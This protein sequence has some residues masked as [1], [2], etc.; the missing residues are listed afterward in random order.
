MIKKLK[1]LDIAKLYTLISKDFKVLSPQEISGVLT[2]T[3]NACF[4][5]NTLS[6]FQTVLSAKSFL[7]SDVYDLEVRP[8]N[9]KIAFFGIHLCDVRAIHILDGILAKDPFYQTKRRDLL[10]VATECQTTEQCFCQTFEANRHTGYDLYIQEEGSENF[11]VFAK[12]EKGVLYLDRLKGKM[13]L[14]KPR[15]I[16]HQK[17]TF[18]SNNLTEIIENR[19]RHQ[20]HWQAIANNCFGCGACTAVCPLCF[21][22]DVID[23]TNPKTG[24]IHRTR[25]LDSCFFS[26]FSKI[27][28]YDYRAKNVDRLYNWYHHKFVRH[29]KH[30]GNFLCVG[31]GR[32]ITACP[33]NLNLKKILF[34]LN[35]MYDSERNDDRSL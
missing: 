9:E 31:C 24:K 19:T 11:T 22:F 8:E 16:G 2:L 18:N 20:D 1:F 27:S 25:K 29:P 15:L 7:L 14:E 32:C 10:I 26:N 34:S 12:T 33:A 28:N 3:E 17:N 4:S 13:A 21:C 30:T 5:H 6:K 35:K 23:S